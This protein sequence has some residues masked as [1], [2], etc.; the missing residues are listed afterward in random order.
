VDF[1]VN[2]KAIEPLG[3][4]KPNSEVFRL[5]AQRMGFTEECFNDSDE[6]IARQAIISNHPN[7]QGLSLDTLKREGW[8]RMNLPDDYAPFAEGKF[9]T[10]SG[11]CE[12]YSEAME[13]MGMDPLPCYIPPAESAQTMPQRAKKYPL[14]VISPPAHSFMNSSFANLPSFLKSEKEPFLEIHPDDAGLRGIKDGDL[15]RIFNDRGAFTARARVSDKARSGVVVALSLWWKKLTDGTNA[16][17]VT[18][19]RL[20]DLGGAATFYDAL[21]DVELHHSHSARSVPIAHS[22]DEP[23]AELVGL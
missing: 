14:A 20:T 9:L 12:F 3:E 23:H 4:S 2:N 7:M 15:V 16:N 11:K 22:V 10:P 13:K 8:Q 19:Q 21:V 5:L 6:E 1:V 17:D 18:S